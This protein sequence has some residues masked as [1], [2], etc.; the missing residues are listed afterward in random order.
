MP[1]KMFNSMDGAVFLGITQVGL[2][3]AAQRGKVPFLWDTTGTN[4]RRRLFREDD[5]IAYRNSQRERLLV[6]LA[7]LDG[8]ECA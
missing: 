4:R 1:S 2:C 8:K 6:R 3:L 7:K 5:L